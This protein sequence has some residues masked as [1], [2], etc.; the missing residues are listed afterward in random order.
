MLD[1]SDIDRWVGVPIGGA[2]LADPIHKNDIRRWAQG[3]QNPNP[4]YFDDDYA[5]QGRFGKIVAPQSF[6]VCTS[7]SHGAAPSIQ[8]RI[9]GSHMLFGGDEWWFSGPRLAPGDRV[10][11]QRVLAGYDVK[12]TKFAGPTVFS[13]GETTYIDADGRTL[14]RQRCTSIRYLVAEAKQRGYWA[15]KSP[16]EPTWTDAEI[17][18]FERKK[19]DYFRTFRELGHARRAGVTVG[20]KLPQR[21][22][23]PHTL[24][25][26]ATEYRSFIMSVWGAFR[27]DG[28]PNSLRQAGWLP[29]MDKN[30]E[31]AKLDPAEADGL[32]K[33]SSRGHV[34]PENAQRIGLPRGYGYGASMGAWV[35]DYVSNWAGEWG[36][37][38]HAKIAL[39]APVFTGDVTFL[40][41]EV[42]DVDAGTEPLAHVSL[43]M[44]NQSGATIASATAEVRLPSEA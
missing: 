23:G 10:R 30:M 36:E 20:Q 39:R 41:G 25:T 42:T 38:E 14:A 6:M 34:Q 5:K 15:D 35:L 11:Q 1:T 26:F 3:M 16:A 40:D 18:A 17:A 43:T 4:A 29:E 33:G 27:P 8:G 12:E 22:I 13:H 21:P 32:Y 9:E 2:D 19:L 37:I 28:L 31:L 24:L 44:T 7:D